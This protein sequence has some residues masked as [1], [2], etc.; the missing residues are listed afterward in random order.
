MILMLPLA[1]YAQRPSGGSASSGSVSSGS[2]SSSA[3][4]RGVSGGVS[5]SSGSYS[6]PSRAVGYSG[7]GGLSPT[8]GY[9][10]R[11]PVTSSFTNYN[12]YP[13]MNFYGWML[14]NYN[15]FQLMQFGLY[16]THRFAVN[17]EPLVTPQMLHLTLETPLAASARLVT[18]VD[19]L[20]A[21]VD[22]MQAG[23]PVPKEEISA[24]T[25]E[26]RELAKRI[27]S[28]PPLAFFDLGK[29]QD[30]A[31]DVDKLGLGAIDQLREMALALN[32]QLKSMYSQSATSTVSVNSLNEASLQSLSK[33]IE[34]L[35]KT[36]ENAKPRS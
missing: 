15:W 20:Q 12:Y 32:S 29:R 35:S 28:Y 31:K 4:S 19:G 5:S 6:E 2:G 21:L 18:A 13:F 1:A 10:P 30:V 25:Q 3:G 33:G 11:F 14:N 24:K 34:K 27:R 7:G 17:R 9:T 26:I 23:K 8:Y 16:D 22:D 36:I